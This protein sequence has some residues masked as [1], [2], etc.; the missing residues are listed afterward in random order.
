[1]RLAR[2]TSLMKELIGGFLWR[3]FPAL[4][5]GYRRRFRRHQ[6]EREYWLVPLFCNP[7]KLAVD[8]GA[9][10]GEYSY[11][12]AG[13]ARNVIAFEPNQD[14]WPHLRRLL[15]RRVRLESAALSASDGVADFRYVEDNTGVATIERSNTLLMI[16][17]RERVKVRSVQTRTLDS[18]DLRDVSFIKIDV[19]GHEEEV[20]E[21]AAA[22]LARERPVL[23][24]ESENRHKPGAPDRLAVRLRGL[25]YSGFYVLGKELR[26]VES[27][28]EEDRDGANAMMPGR[29]YINNYVFIPAGRDDLLDRIRH[30]VETT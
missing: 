29:T 27:I 6:F 10:M 30:A 13:H 20:V 23:L 12:M 21:G 8:V 28:R 3:R 16:A 7:Q 1:M 17:E 2:V 5:L 14:L 11:Y 26:P 19:E 24:I 18:Y 9:N 4:W 15:G 22:T 25:G